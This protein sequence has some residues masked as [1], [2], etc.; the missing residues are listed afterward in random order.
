MPKA[1]LAVMFPVLFG[2]LLA[3]CGGGGDEPSKSKSDTSTKTAKKDDSGKKSDKD[4]GKSNEKGSNSAPVAEGTGTLV[5]TITFSG[6]APS[7]DPLVAAGAEVKDP[8]VCAVNAVP[9]ENVVV[10]ESGGLAN[11]F[12]YLAKAPEGVE[13]RDPAEVVIDQKGCRF[14][15]HATVSY[16]EDTVR[17]TSSDD[18]AHNVHTFPIKNTVI[19]SLM[20]ANDQTGLE[21]DL[22]KAEIL[23]FQ[24][25][26]DI[27]SW[28]VHYHLVLDHPFAAVTDETGSFRIEGLPVG[29]HEFRIW[30][31]SKGYLEKKYAV[32]ITK[33]AETSVELEYTAADLDVSP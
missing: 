13:P 1:L 32:E 19:N 4:E 18:C 7:L 23:P 17:V 15:P 14:F 22:S 26:C 8:T 21:L 10:A 11:V 5:G 27:H 2:L 9:D 31:E 6:D 29:T 25:K 33:D 28:M 24:I 12:V 20:Q 3:G 16:T 30:H